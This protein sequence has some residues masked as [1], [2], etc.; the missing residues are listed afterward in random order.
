MGSTSAANKLTSRHPLQRL[1]SPSPTISA[2]IHLIGL[3]SFS[4]S[5]KYLFD[6]PT[7][8]N[9]SYGWHFQYLTIIGLTLAFLTFVFGFL[10][11]ITLSPRLFLIKNSLS[12][13]SA[14]LEVLISVLY[15]GISAIDKKLLVPPEIY[16]S[17]Y[18]DV[19]FHAMPAILLT[20][21]LLFLSPPWTINA[22]PA[23]GLSST[24]A[25]AYWAWVEQ[26]YKYNGF[27]P[28]PLFGHLD[29]TQRAILFTGAALTMTGSTA[30]LK[31][32]YGRVNGLQRAQYRSSPNNIK[33]R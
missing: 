32:L 5:Y 28:Y 8:I 2:L 19:G 20:I 6:F 9:S 22:L 24:L 14:P 1:P 10:A 4:L 30:V 26:C 13:C 17:P 18:A 21:D 15:W 27:Y 12:L 11:D 33:G 3:A 31:W 23:M 16:I 25:V 29:T 7:F